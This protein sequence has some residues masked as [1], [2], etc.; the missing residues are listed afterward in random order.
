V[1][2]AS[3]SADLCHATTSHTLDLLHKD[4]LLVP[5]GFVN[6]CAMFL[7]TRALTET[8][9]F[10]DRLF[11]CW[12][13]VELPFRLRAASWNVG[14]VPAARI[15]HG[16]HGSVG[17]AVASNYYYRNAILVAQP[18]RAFLLPSRLHP[19]P[20]KSR[21][22]AVERGRHSTRLTL[23]GLLTAIG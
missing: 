21:I 5:T 7:R 17:S 10:W 9:L 18:S 22:P 14:V 20:V 15:Q 12:E 3:G 2:Y 23:S 19:L 11:L 4:A 6:G 13:D 8:G 1:W 16:V